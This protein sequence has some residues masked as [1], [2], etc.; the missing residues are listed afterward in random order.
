MPDTFFIGDHKH[1]FPH[2]L[3]KVMVQQQDGE[4]FRDNNIVLNG[5]DLTSV[6]GQ[7]SVKVCG[8]GILYLMSYFVFIHLN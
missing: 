4:V 3:E 6:K 2:M 1:M 8:F 5:T 7:P